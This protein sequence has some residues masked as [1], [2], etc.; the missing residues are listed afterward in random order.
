MAFP[1]KIFTSWPF[2]LLLDEMTMGLK[3]I[4]PTEEVFQLLYSKDFSV[5]CP[6]KPHGNHFIQRESRY[7]G[8]Q[9]MCKGPTLNYGCK[10][11]GFLD[12]KVSPHAKR[13]GGGKAQK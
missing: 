7:R 8:Q 10:I 3:I 11:F 12:V 9:I 6:N 4:C 1:I 13:H 2:I 5:F